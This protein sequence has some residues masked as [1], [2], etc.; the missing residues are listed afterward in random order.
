MSNHSKLEQPNP[1]D[2]KSVFKDPELSSVNSTKDIDELPD[3]MRKLPDKPIKKPKKRR[4][5]PWI[6]LAV[7]IA[8]LAVA[9]FFAYRVYASL[10]KVIVK[11]TGVAA[12]GLKTEDIAPEKLK[13]EGDGRVNVLMLGVGDPGH[14]GEQLTDTI[15]VASYDPKSKDVAMVSLPRDLMVNVAGSSVRINSAYYYGEQNKKG[16][17]PEIAKQTVSKVLGIPVHYFIKLDFSALKQAVDSVGGIDINV[18]KTLVDPEYPCEKNESISCGYSIMAGPQ[19]LNGSAALK[20]A[21]CRKGD[22]GDDF[23]RAMRQQQVIVALRQ[24]ANT[25]NLLTNPAKI[26]EVLQIIGDNVRTDLQLWEIERFAQIGRE[27]DPTKINNKV[28]DGTSGLVKNSN[29]GGASVL[30]PSA[31]PGNFSGIQAFVRQLFADGYIK[32]EA[33]NIAIENGTT[34]T[35]RGQ[36]TA[37]LLKTYGYTI[38]TVIPADASTYKTTKII[39]YTGGKKPYT[40]QYLQKRFGVVATS[41]DPASA[42]APN[43]DIAIIVGANYKP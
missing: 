5:W 38:A 30:I 8:L 26:S 2:D 13:G 41:A 1:N 11:N 16:S 15:M 12:E 10:N 22:C 4:R 20:Y 6:V 3:F 34:I 19:H 27:I 33:A 39:D 32:S 35:T 21:R 14:A 25:Q 7:F 23:G 24:K 43:V 29:D 40:L 31:G 17:G 37:D 28:V 36:A 42:P 18:D 9:G